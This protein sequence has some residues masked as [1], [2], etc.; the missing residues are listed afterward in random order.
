M[1][2]HLVSMVAAAADSIHLA[3]RG[4]CPQYAGDTHLLPVA[5]VRLLLLEN[6]QLTQIASEGEALRQ[7]L[8]DFKRDAEAHKARLKESV[9]VHVSHA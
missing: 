7:S 2:T 3:D 4:T 1:L 9:C 8:M 6:A 5:Q